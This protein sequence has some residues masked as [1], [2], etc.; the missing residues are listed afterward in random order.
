MRPAGCVRIRDAA[1]EPASSPMTPPLKPLLLLLPCALLAGC[2]TTRQGRPGQ[3]TVVN[4]TVRRERNTHADPVRW[5]Q[6]VLGS[7][8]KQKLSGYVKTELIRG[9]PPE[10]RYQQWIY[11]TDFNLIGHQSPLG[12]TWRVDALGRRQKLGSFN[13]KH[14]IL[15]I[16]GYLDEAE[17]NLV[18]MPPPA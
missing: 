18:R 6:I 14:A 2:L 1:L 4:Q 9:A 16:F 15:S 10:T 12:V 5:R 11:D 3:R 7:P 17:V 8:P 13:L